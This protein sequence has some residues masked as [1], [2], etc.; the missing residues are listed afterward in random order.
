[1]ASKGWL[2]DSIAEFWYQMTANPLLFMAVVLTL[3]VILVN[4]WTDAPNAIA[5]CVVTRCMP[6]VNNQEGTK[7]VNTKA[8]D[9]TQRLFC[10]RV[11]MTGRTIG[12]RLVFE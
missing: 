12:L 5:T 4:G 2:M 1:M 11:I 7:C 10:Y 6:Q 3:G 8:V 9:Q